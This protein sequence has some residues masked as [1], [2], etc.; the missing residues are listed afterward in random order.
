MAVKAG[1]ILHDAYGFVIDR[2]QTGGVSGLNIP[3]EKIYELGNFN[4]VATVRDTPDL[5][6]GME[7]LDVSTEIEALLT[8]TDPDST[9]D[10]D[11]FDLAECVPMDIISPLKD[12]WNIYTASHGI[13]VPY[14][15]RESSAYRFEVE[16][17]A[18]QNH[19]L[20]GD[21]VFFTDGSPYYEE[22]LGDG[23]TATFNLA[24]TAQPYNYQGATRYVL[25][26]SV[27]YADKTYRRLFLTSDYTNDTTSF[28]LLDPTLAPTG[29]TIR[30]VY[31]S[32]EVAT[33]PQTVHEGVSVKPAAVR[34]KSVDIYVGTNAATPTFGRWS[35]VQSAEI[36]HSVTLDKDM[37][38]GNS[39]AVSQDH[40]V[41]EVSGSIT[42]RPRDVDEFFAKIK[43]VAN[44]GSGEVAGAL[45]SVAL[46]LEVRV[47]DP[48]TGVRLK[49]LYVPDARFKVPSFEGRVQ[50]KQ[51]PV[52][53]WT[54]DGGICLIYQGNR[55]GT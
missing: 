17:N 12:N 46:P 9:V 27:V 47:S 4:A 20:R 29:S 36:N 44:V 8:F 52:F 30:V 11:E 24:H 39:E 43:Q 32:S 41:P 25:G 50:Q 51:E 10:G 40:D 6:F 7:S 48:D 16:G 35:S 53:E 26:A 34:G 49:T 42:V 5:T 33:Y 13:V 45:T 15:Y 22:F 18:S 37:E 55:Y 19:T 23:S 2:I 21:A 54:S 38:F 31:G 1:Q 28:T 14:L 3:E